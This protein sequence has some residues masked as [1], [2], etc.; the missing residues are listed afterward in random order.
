M[1]RRKTSGAFGNSFYNL[2]KA[3]DELH[4]RL[5]AHDELTL[6]HEE[7]LELFVQEEYRASFMEV[8]QR[9]ARRH[10]SMFRVKWELNDYTFLAKVELDVTLCDVDGVRHPFVPDPV[11]MRFEEGSAL[12]ERV[13]SWVTR[14]FHLGLEF[15][16]VRK[17]LNLMNSLCDTPEQ[18]R[19]YWPAV[20]TLCKQAALDE[21]VDRIQ[22]GR[23]SSKPPGLALREAC[24]VT[25]GTITGASLV[26]PVSASSQTAP[27][28]I[29]FA[30]GSY[31]Q[32]W[33]EE[34]IG[35]VDVL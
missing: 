33:V 7:Y 18:V 35:T 34:A 9:V 5:V 23:P 8:A 22:V 4:A 6:T 20:Q 16:R 1:G 3:V 29:T 31:S 15:G 11:F 21:L 25:S 30:D 19:Y 14:R 27:C 28:S 32:R 17:V 12:I 10:S 2:S 24:R 26:D 13:T